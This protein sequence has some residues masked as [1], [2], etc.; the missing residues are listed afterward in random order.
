MALTRHSKGQ[1]PRHARA[2]DE[3]AI[4]TG[5]IGHVILRVLLEL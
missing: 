2:S 4:Y 1:Q 3:G 5:R